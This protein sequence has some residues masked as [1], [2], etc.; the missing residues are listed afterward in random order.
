MKV[1]LRLMQVILFF[2]CCLL[3]G[4]AL[5]IVKIPMYIVIGEIVGEPLLQ[6]LFEID[7]NKDKKQH[8]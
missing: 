8:D 3:D 5:F 4:I 6:W 7:I 1:L 2:P